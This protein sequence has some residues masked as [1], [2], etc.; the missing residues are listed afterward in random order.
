MPLIQSSR[1]SPGMERFVHSYVQREVQLGLPSFLHPLPART[2]SAIVF[3]FRDPVG[4]ATLGTPLLRT[5]ERITLVGSKT[6]Q[7]SQLLVGGN[8]ESF[9]IF[10]QPTAIA[11]LFGMPAF[12]ITNCDCAAE[13]VIGVAVLEFG[14]RLGNANTFQRRVQIADE[15]F[16]RQSFRAPAPDSIELAANEIIRTQGRCRIDSLAH[17]T[18]LGMRSFQRTF[19]RRVGVS[20]KLYSRIARFETALRAK[21]C[22]PQLSWTTIAHEFGYHDQMHMIHDFQQLSGETPTG[23]LG[24]TAE[25]F[26]QQLGSAI[27]PDPSQLVL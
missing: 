27:N 7:R 4:I 6:Y 13:G 23:I 9:S 8:S 18:G 16:V 10:L 26:A 1:P 5:A 24:S 19:Q 11:H 3:E 12:E 14:Q 22:A 20:P 17:H 25:I 2:A 21:V 15:F